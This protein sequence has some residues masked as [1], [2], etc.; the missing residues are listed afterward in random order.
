M[1]APTWKCDTGTRAKLLTYARC[2]SST[3]DSF[4]E[5]LEHLLD[6]FIPFLEERVDFLLLVP[7]LDIGK[8]DHEKVDATNSAQLFT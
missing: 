1:A 2:A 6:R 5:R 8:I 3:R 4:V 7:Q